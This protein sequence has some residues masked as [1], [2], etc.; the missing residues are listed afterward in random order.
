MN[1][2]SAAASGD[3]PSSKPAPDPYARA[4]ALHRLPASACVAIEDSRWGIVSAKTAGLSC[5]GITNTYPA[6][7]LTDADLVIASLDEFTGA[8]IEQLRAVT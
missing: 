4:A 8:L 3:T 2:A 6:S 7:E 5:I 1:P